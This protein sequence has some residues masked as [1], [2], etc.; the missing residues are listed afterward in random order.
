MKLVSLQLT[1]KEAKDEATMV[2]DEPRYPWG[3]SLHLDED[4]LKKL[5]IEEMPSVGTEFP[6]TAVAKVTGTSERET[7]DGSRATLDL[8]IVKMALG[9]E[10]E[11]QS[12]AAKKLYGDKEK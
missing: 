12:P 5:G 1:K 3:T 9:D 11:E 2:P 10:D 4:E 8:Q 7:Q 6:I